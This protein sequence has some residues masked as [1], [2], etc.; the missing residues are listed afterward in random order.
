M[1]TIPIAERDFIT[2]GCYSVWI[3]VREERLELSR[4][5]RSPASKT[6]VATITPLTHILLI[7]C[8]Y[9]DLNQDTY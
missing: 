9:L 2:R 4:A 1:S 6:G 3:L 5:L 8:A 7:W